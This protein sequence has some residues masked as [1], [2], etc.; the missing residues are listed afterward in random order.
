MCRIT[1]NKPFI[2][3]NYVDTYM[4]L[5]QL[6][7]PKKLRH[8]M[9]WRRSSHSQRTMVSLF[10]SW[11][12]YNIEHA[13]ETHITFKSHKIPFVHSICYN[14]SIVLTFCIMHGNYIAGPCAKCQDDWVIQTDIMYEWEFA[15]LEFKICIYRWEVYFALSEIW[16]W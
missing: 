5:S 9:F 12:L 4:W 10:E 1:F 14:H 7:I 15:R 11:V 8:P 16:C 13:S 3:S 2:T 6:S